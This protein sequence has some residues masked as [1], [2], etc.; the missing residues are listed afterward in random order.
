MKDVRAVLG[1]S[2]LAA[3]ATS[4]LLTIFN[5]MIYQ[6]R[7]ADFLPAMIGFLVGAFFVNTLIACTLGLMWHAFVEHRG[8]TSIH[9]YWP[10]AVLVG[11]AVPLALMLLPLMQGPPPLGPAV[12]NHWL[13]TFLLLL[14]LG[15]S[16]G[17]LTAVFAWLIRRPDRD[18][19]NPPT[20]EP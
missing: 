14:A 19:P 3:V 2:A 12:N 16:L 6:G 17:G 10:P 9:A 15:V 18:A 4:A 8:W 1:G 11:A 20:S 13:F 5:V 7:S